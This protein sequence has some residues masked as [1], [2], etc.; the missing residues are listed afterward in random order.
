M[1]HYLALRGLRKCIHPLNDTTRRLLE[2]HSS[3]IN[4]GVRFL[5]PDYRI[6]FAL[7]E[8]R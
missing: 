1:K 6:A 7:I 5:V 3:N 4:N 8:A 2:V